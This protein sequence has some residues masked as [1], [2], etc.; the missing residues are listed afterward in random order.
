MWA[1]MELAWAGHAALQEADGRNRVA[2]MEL[3][4]GAPVDLGEEDGRSP[5]QAR[6]EVASVP[7]GDEDGDEDEDGDVHGAADGKIRAEA[8]M[9]PVPQVLSDQVGQDGRT[10]AQARRAGAWVDDAG[11]QVVDGGRKHGD[12]GRRAGEEWV[13]HGALEVVGSIH[14]AVRMEVA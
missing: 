5:A 1:H 13:G 7:H 12:G 6:K 4:S 8:H 3:A 10:H 2:H 11:P 14:E 9:A